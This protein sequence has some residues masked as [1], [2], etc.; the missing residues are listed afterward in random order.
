MACP[1]C[2]VQSVFVAVRT[3]IRWYYAVRAV[4]GHCRRRR[5]RRRRLAEREH[6]II[7][8]MNSFSTSDQT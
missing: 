5:R 7:M 3:L 2:R 8:M 4:V 1:L 6:I